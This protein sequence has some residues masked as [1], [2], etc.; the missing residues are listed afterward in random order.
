MMEWKPIEEAGEQEDVLL[1]CS[2]M[3]RRGENGLC[4]GR[5]IVFDDGEQIVRADG[6]T[7]DWT[8][9]HWMPLPPPPGDKQ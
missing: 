4:R 2:D 8:F 1:W 9:T 6:M 5:I 3:E 7:G